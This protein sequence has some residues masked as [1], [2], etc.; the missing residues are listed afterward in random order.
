MTFQEKYGPWAIVAGASEGTGRSL[1]RRIAAEGVSC[2]LIAW[3]GP[4]EEVAQEIRTECG[5]ACV[6]ANIDLSAPDAFD[7]IR[8]AAD[9]REIGL[10][11]ANAGSDR[12]GSRYLDHDVADWLALLRLNVTTTMQACHH[13]GNLMRSRRRGGLLI[14]NSGACYGGGS[15]LATYTGCK[16]F[17]QFLGRNLGGTAA[18]RRRRPQHGSRHDRHTDVSEAAR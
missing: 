2:I 14:I 13:F 8:E 5:V 15:F 11:V 18:L 10:Y 17:A 12:F 6:T 3:G 9:D 1:A 4:L 16:G 7:R